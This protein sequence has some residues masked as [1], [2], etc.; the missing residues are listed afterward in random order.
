MDPRVTRVSDAQMVFEALLSHR[1]SLKELVIHSCGY[2]ERHHEVP[3]YGSFED[4]RAIRTLIVDYNALS[5]GNPLLPLLNSITIQ[6]CGIMQPVAALLDIC[7][8]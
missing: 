3:K 6:N 2:R 5:V 8:H 7:K 4:F 1:D